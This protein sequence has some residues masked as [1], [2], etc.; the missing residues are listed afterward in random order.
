MNTSEGE[1]KVTTESGIP[2]KK[3]FRPDDVAGL[4]YDRDLGDSGQPPFTRGPYPDMYRSRAWRIAQNMGSGSPEDVSSRVKFFQQEGGDWVNVQIDQIINHH[5]W[6][7]DHP[8]VIA[9]KDDV[10]LLGAP[11][12]GLRDW[13]VMLEGIPLDKAYIHMGGWPWSNSCVYAIAE[14]RGVPLDKLQGTGQGEMFIPYVSAPYKDIPPPSCHLRNNCDLIEFNVKYVPHVV[15]ISCA[16][17]NIRSNGITAYEE[18][19]IV[20][21]WNIEHI[22]AVLKRGRLK[23]DDFAHALGGVNYSIGRDFFEEIAKI[24]AARRMWYKLLNERYHAQNPRSSLLR[25]HGFSADRD[26]TREQ[27]L[28]NIVRSSYR[29]LSAALAGVQSLGVGPYDEGITTPTPESLLMAVRTQQVIQNESGVTNV[30]DPLAGSYYV[31]WLTNE[32]EE[33][34]WKYLEKIENAGGFIKTLESGWLH[35]EAFRGSWEQEKKLKTGERK[36]VGHNCFQTEEDVFDVPPHRPA[37]AWE[38]AMAR[39]EQMR[40]E[41]DPARVSKA[42][43]NLRRVIAKPDEIQIPA[44][45]E[46]VKAEATVG[47]IGQVYRDIWGVWNAPLPI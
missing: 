22:E 36:L 4:Q 27:P 26:Y 31:E 5:F 46:A 14:K 32:V 1:E 33:R 42:L 15:P 39:L 28:V 10:G 16:G 19:A 7:P 2:L 25:V 3:I 44:M 6:D 38:Q 35:A 43:D 47:E 13:E 18:L 11:A 17:H 40:R 37:K 29:V 12:V 21:A 8:E 24:R 41:R 20:L 23:I 9:R 45:M 34:A 30:V